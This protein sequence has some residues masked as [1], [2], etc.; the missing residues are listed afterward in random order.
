M[1]KFIWVTEIMDINLLDSDKVNG[2]IVLDA[3]ASYLNEDELIDSFLF[4]LI[5]GKFSCNLSNWTDLGC[6]DKMECYKNNLKGKWNNW[7]AL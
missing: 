1:P 7:R 5:N 3:T 4:I 2:F 6:N